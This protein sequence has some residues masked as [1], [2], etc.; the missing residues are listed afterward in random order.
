[1]TYVFRQKFMTYVFRQKLFRQDLDHFRTYVFTQFYNYGFT[2]FQDFMCLEILELQRILGNLELYT[3]FSTLG[4]FR[5][6]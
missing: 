4:D 3:I 6:L 2:Q 5:G 1:M